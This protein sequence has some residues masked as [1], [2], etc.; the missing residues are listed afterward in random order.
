MN[1]EKY[2]PFT[3]LQDFLN[4][5]GFID[6][7]INPTK[8][9]N[10]FWQSYIISYPQKKDIIQKAADTIK[11]YRA[12]DTFYNEGHKDLL[13]ARIE[14]SIAAEPVT[15]NRKKVFGL[16]AFMR[17]AAALIIVAG[18]SFWMLNRNAAAKQY[19]FTTTFGEVKTITLPDQ[20]QVTLNG[21]SSI[22]YTA[23]WKEK[24]VREV[25]INGEC[26]FNVTHLNKDTANIKAEERFIV[27][28]SDVNI[29]VLGT[30]FNVKARHGKTNV[31]LITGKI[32]IDY[33]D[34]AAKAKTV[35]MAPGDYVEYASTKLL[36]SKKL[37][38]PASISTW[39]AKEI[40][41]T[42]AT[43]KE[44]T[45]TLQDNYGYTVHVKDTSLLSLKIEGDISVN[46]ITDLLDVVGTTLNIKIEQPAE[47][48]ITITK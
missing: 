35:I 21:N 27:H 7:I 15:A 8:E 10:A 12:Q 28:C 23:N 45:E 29:E 17:V 36:V 2:A 24:K 19:S 30:T 16:P 22:S 32:R 37:V 43:L 6:W 39:R 33:T 20:S 34:A 3:T 13:L 25:W 9:K 26:Y 5:D 1:T 31:A 44:I 48:N 38:K 42:D 41:F 47:K 46:N 18:L 40:S 14:A 4:D 11:Q